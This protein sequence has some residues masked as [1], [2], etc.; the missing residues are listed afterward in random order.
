MIQQL[1]VEWPSGLVQT[2]PDEQVTTL[3]T[4]TLYTITEP[5]N[6]VTINPAQNAAATQTQFMEVS[7]AVGLTGAHWE[8][9]FDDFAVQPLLPRKLSVLGP[10]LAWGDA[11][12]DGLDDLY[13]TGAKGQAGLLYHNLG[14]GQFVPTPTGSVANEEELAALW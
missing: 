13:L 12:G 5:E 10:G 2:F 8:S 4:N 7:Q 14:N 3:A 11:N 1:Q 9:T 6:A